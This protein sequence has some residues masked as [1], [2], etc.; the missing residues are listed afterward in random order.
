MIFS[1]ALFSFLAFISILIFCI[2]C[3]ILIDNA[4]LTSSSEQLCWGP[5]GHLRDE[6]FLTSYHLEM[7]A[8]SSKGGVIV[9]YPPLKHT[10]SL[11]FFTYE[12]LKEKAI[13]DI[14][15]LVFTCYIDNG[16]AVTYEISYPL[17]IFVNVLFG[18]LSIVFL[19]FAFRKNR[20]EEGYY[21]LRF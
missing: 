2:T 3:S 16:I 15:S 12:S 10:W 11:A 20:D 21:S 14:S 19:Y 18:L 9:Y 5:F 1:K 4:I 17:W 7:T 6:T 13:Q 8:S